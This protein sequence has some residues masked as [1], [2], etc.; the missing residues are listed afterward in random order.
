[1]DPTYLI[2]Q[3]SPQVFGISGTAKLSEL[4]NTGWT[5]GVSLLFLALFVALVWS[6]IGMI[7]ASST[8]NFHSHSNYK[9]LLR[10]VVYSI[11][12]VL[13]VS[14]FIFFVMKG[15]EFLDFDNKSTQNT[16]ATVLTPSTTPNPSVGKG[17]HGTATPTCINPQL[18]KDTLREMGDGLCGG[19]FCKGLC[20]FK[21]DIKQIAVSEARSAGVDPSIILALI[22]RESSGNPEAKGVHANNGNPDCGLM[23]INS[24][25]CTA[26]IMDPTNNVRAGIQLYKAKLASVSS[27]SY[28]GTNK[29]TLAFAAYNC[30]ANGDNPNSKSADCN[31]GTGWSMD[32]PKWAC[33][34]NPG[35]GSFNMCAVKNYTCDVTACA[36][37][38]AKGL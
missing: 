26:D 3:D 7:H 13:F 37:E 33:P 28:A 25:S 1:M 23:Q 36:R 6:S 17:R 14:V 12:A 18:Y 20:N 32:L 16:G 5:F 10:K 11:I 31:L 2:N 22:C 4:A 30:C 29:P 24:Q 34:I 15:F 8:G 19:T 27:Y 35:T 9:E 21:A 38:Y